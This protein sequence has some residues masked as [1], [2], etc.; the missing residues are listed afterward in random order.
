MTMLRFEP[1]KRVGF[2]HYLRGDGTYSYFFDLDYVRDLF[3]GAGFTEVWSC[4][5]IVY[6]CPGYEVLGSIELGLTKI[7]P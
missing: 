7:T 5:R 4:I 2:K 3:V 1:D 6:E